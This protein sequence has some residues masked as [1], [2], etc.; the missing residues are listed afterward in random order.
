ML[1][2]VL[3]KIIDDESQGGDGVGR[4]NNSEAYPTS[5]A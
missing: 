5:K 2:H 3:S 1:R 4:L